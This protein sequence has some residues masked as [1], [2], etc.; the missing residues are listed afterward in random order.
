[1]LPIRSGMP[2]P[3]AGLLD[4]VTAQGYGRAQEDAIVAS[5]PPAAGITYPRE[6]LRGARTHS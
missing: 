6:P 5:P 1:M 4:D 2:R 3:S